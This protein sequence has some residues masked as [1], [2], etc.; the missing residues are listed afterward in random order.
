MDKMWICTSGE[1][2][3]CVASLLHKVVVQGVSHGG[4]VGILQ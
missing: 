4:S 3:S 1:I 2:S